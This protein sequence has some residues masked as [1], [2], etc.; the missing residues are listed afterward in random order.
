MFS[1]Y[2]NVVGVDE[3]VVEVDDNTD[4]KHVGEDVVHKSL[5][6]HWGIGESKRHNLP[7]K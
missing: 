4:I 3:D 6:R 7:F 2:L 1:V 5:E